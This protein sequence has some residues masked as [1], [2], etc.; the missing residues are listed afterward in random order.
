MASYWYSTDGMDHKRLSSRHLDMLDNAYKNR[1]RIKIFDDYAFGPEVAAIADPYLGTMTAGEI[2]FG[3]YRNPSLRVSGDGMDDLD[4]L[5]LLDS[6]AAMFQFPSSSS[7]SSSSTSGSSPSTTDN[8][9]LVAS[10]NFLGQRRHSFPAVKNNNSSKKR[11]MPSSTPNRSTGQPSN[12]DECVCCIISWADVRYSFSF[13]F[14]CVYNPFF[15]Y[16]SLFNIPVHNLSLFLSR[17][18]LMLFFF[19]SS[20]SRVTLMHWWFFSVWCTFTIMLS[21]FPHLWIFP[22]HSLAAYSPSLCPTTKEKQI[23][24]IIIQHHVYHHQH[25]EQS[26]YYRSTHHQQGSATLDVI[27]CRSNTGECFMGMFIGLDCCWM[28]M[29]DRQQCD[30]WLVQ[31]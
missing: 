7:S 2:H 6:T 26:H 1:T 23:I 14:T 13:T 17:P 18:S 12:Q 8:C 3:L 11:S 19:F 21:S 28:M 9:V 24:I 22:S 27:L 4:N 10:H 30:S 16:L 25:K 5:I 15:H 20:I 29:S 31:A